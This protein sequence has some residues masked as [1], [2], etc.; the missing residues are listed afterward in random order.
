MRREMQVSVLQLRL[1][2]TFSCQRN[3]WRFNGLTLHGITEA[4]NNLVPMC[5]EF[6]QFFVQIPLEKG[7]QNEEILLREVICLQS[8]QA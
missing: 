4:L 8:Y 1:A 5:F 7:Q 6:K 3:E 2:T